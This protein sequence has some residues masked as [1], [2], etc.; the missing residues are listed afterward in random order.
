MSDKPKFVEEK[1]KKCGGTGK[2]RD[3]SACKWCGGTGK[4]RRPVKEGE[5]AQ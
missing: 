2:R 1:C 5:R 3:K 4:F